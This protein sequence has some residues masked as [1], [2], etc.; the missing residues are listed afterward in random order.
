MLAM[1][2]DSLE[3]GID[4]LALKAFLLLLMMLFF[5]LPQTIKIYK[6]TYSETHTFTV[7]KINN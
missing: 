1:I 7:N 5:N 6:H 3:I 2:E 4:L